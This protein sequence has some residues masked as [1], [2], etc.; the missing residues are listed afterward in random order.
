MNTNNENRVG[1]DVVDALYLQY[2]QQLTLF[3]VGLLRDHQLATDVVQS[4]FVKFAEQGHKTQQESRKSWLFRVAYNEAMA[5]RRREQVGSKIHEKIA[6]GLGSSTEADA[7]DKKL[8]QAETIKLVRDALERLPAEHRQIVQKRIYEEKKFATIADELG[9]P[10]G[11]VL[12]RMRNALA[13]LR[14]ALPVE[15]NENQ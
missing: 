13:K 10:L 3:L 5:I 7:P 12:T 9:I 15:E 1:S 4:T 2:S 6:W 11:T 8:I 14:N